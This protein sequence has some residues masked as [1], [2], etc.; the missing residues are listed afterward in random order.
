MLFKK[1]NSFKYTLKISKFISK[2]Y[3]A[4]KCVEE[5]TILFRAKP[6]HTAWLM[7]KRSIRPPLAPFIYTNDVHYFN[8]HWFEV[9]PASLWACIIVTWKWTRNT[10]R[11]FTEFEFL[12][13]TLLPNLFKTMRW[14]S[15]NESNLN[16]VLLQAT[17]TLLN[18]NYH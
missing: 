15:T 10:T 7:K 12:L 17:M 4:I 2:K 9:F 13:K 3:I 6:S 5:C 11:S 16:A 8:L 14:W 1:L 18:N